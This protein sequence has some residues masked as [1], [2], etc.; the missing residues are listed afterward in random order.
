MTCTLQSIFLE[1]G[2]VWCIIGES[3]VDVCSLN[4]KGTHFPTFWILPRSQS[5]D[6][7]LRIKWSLVYWRRSSSNNSFKS[8][9]SIKF[10]LSVQLFFELE[11][12]QTN[13]G[14]LFLQEHQCPILNEWILKLLNHIFLVLIHKECNVSNLT[15]QQVIF[16]FEYFEKVYSK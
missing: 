12:V 6:F 9:F 7:W 10:S 8:S 15:Y 14:M 4:L 1:F 2:W 13:S 16:E 5:Q 3:L 11:I